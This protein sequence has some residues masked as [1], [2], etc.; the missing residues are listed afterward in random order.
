MHRFVLHLSAASRTC[1]RANTPLPELSFKSLLGI[2]T[3]PPGLQIGAMEN[4]RARGSG[5]GEEKPGAGRGS[6][7]RQPGAAVV[8]DGRSVPW[9]PAVR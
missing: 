5:R 3:E 9:K 8:S 4:K 6:L 1:F 7:S 2:Q